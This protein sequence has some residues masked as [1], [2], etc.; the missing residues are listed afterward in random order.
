[1][2]SINLHV[3]VETKESLRNDVKMLT[4]VISDKII[5]HFYFVF[6]FHIVKYSLI[7]MYYSFNEKDMNLGNYIPLKEIGNVWL[8]YLVKS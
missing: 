5:D 2:H 3:Y 7:G 4:V 1:M 8:A 6:N